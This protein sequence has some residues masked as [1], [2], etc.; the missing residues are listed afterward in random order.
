MEN[1]INKI[2][3][4]SI[5]TELQ[6]R[7]ISE[8]ECTLGSNVS[9]SFFSDWKAG[10]SKAPSFDKIYRIAQFLNLS[11]DTLIGNN[12]HSETS[13]YNGKL[14]LDEINLLDMYKDI[15]EYGKTVAQN[16]L[17]QIWADYRLGNNSSET[18]LDPYVELEK[19]LN[20]DE[21]EQEPVRFTVAAFGGK[22]C[23]ERTISRKEA[24]IAIKELNKMLERENEDI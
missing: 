19:L 17:R 10:R 11:I 23:E 13:I 3:L 1:D 5:L 18:K 24:D 8:K 12:T 2:L 21:E 16:K 22:G 6:S 9:Q 14:S 15:T 4:S 20:D 7:N